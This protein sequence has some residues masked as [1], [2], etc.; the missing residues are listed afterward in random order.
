M[1]EKRAFEVKDR[2]YLVEK[3]EADG[4]ITLTPGVIIQVVETTTLDDE[5]Y[6][7]WAQATP[8]VTCEYTWQ[9][10]IEDRLIADNVV[11]FDNIGR[12][13]NRKDVSCIRENDLGS[14]VREVL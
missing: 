9:K 10:T 13:I 5:E 2:A 7:N 12:S 11:Q 4:S 6:E 1:A 14:K 8:I 3:D